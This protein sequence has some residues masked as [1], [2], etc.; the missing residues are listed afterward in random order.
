M[1]VFISHNSAD[2]KF[3]RTLKTDLNENG[4]DTFFDEDS[5]EFGDSLMERLEEG[6]KES[7]HFIIIL[8][9]NSIKSNWVKNELKE[10]LKLF[11]EK[12]IKKIIPI[13]SD[14]ILN[15]SVRVNIKNPP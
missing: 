11:D 6:I 5:L 4:I 14:E 12:T 8:T 7:S 9:P 3:V 10:A 15:H 2:K 13:N 1:K